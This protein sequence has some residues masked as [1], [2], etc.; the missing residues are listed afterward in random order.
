MI[1]P[2]I[3]KRIAQ[4][5]LHTNQRIT[6]LF[7][8]AYRSIFKGRGLEFESVRQY[9]PGDDVR[10]IDWKVTA[11]TGV[12][13]IRQYVE[14]RQ[15]T[16]MVLIDGSQSLFFGT[17]YQEKRQVAA[18]LGSAIAMTASRNRDRTGL[19]IFTDE[20]ERIIPPSSNPRH[21]RRILYDILTFKPERKQTHIGKALE[22]ANRLLSRGSVVFILSD[23]LQDV[24]TY[25][26]AFKVT[27]QA[28]DVTAI[29]V[30]DP[31]ESRFPVSGMMALEDAETK[32]IQ[33]VDPKSKAWQQ[34]FNRNVNALTQQRAQLMRQ[35]GAG[36]FEITSRDDY[37]GKLIEYL[38][39]RASS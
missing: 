29:I 28:H 24:D 12:P 36:W 1:T 4:I 25:A 8:G 14:E 23:F 27:A 34:Q 21:A 32:Q 17:Q 31:I 35:S 30:N 18:E 26:K 3:L 37:V 10:L 22:T 11:R 15:L 5:E 6:S 7:S 20:C 16:V 33:W 13:Y 19:I 39:D 9:E 2:S 38:R